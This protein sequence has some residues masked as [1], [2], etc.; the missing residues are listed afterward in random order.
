MTDYTDARALAERCL[1]TSTNSAAH[2]IS[3]A[4]LAAL[5]ELEEARERCSAVENAGHRPDCGGL[6]EVNRR[7]GCGWLQAEDAHGYIRKIERE[8]EEAKRER[9]GLTEALRA[10]DAA[11]RGRN[12][13]LGLRLR[14]IVSRAGLGPYNESLGAPHA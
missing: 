1:E 3:R 6:D 11:V 9:D 5:G 2:T 14:D 10:V 8:R 12:D 7:C 13:S 4:L